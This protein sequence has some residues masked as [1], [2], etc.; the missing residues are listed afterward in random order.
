MENLYRFLYFC[1][2][3]KHYKNQMSKR[4][5]R[6]KVKFETSSNNK[7]YKIE[8]ICNSLFYMRELEAGDLSGLYYLIF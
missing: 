3:V 1:T 7:K 6:E 8:D 2:K 4:E 5:D